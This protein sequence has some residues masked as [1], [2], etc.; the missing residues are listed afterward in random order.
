MVI[1][2]EPPL[3]EGTE[4]A[5]REPILA[6]ASRTEGRAALRFGAAG[7][8]RLGL[9]A[10]RLG[11]RRGRFAGAFFAFRRAIVLF[12]KSFADPRCHSQ[13]RESAISH[14]SVRCV[15]DQGRLFIRSRPRGAYQTQGLLP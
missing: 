11:A 6:G 12:C 13:I 15:A 14:L 3:N 9:G 10:A 4:R 7:A 1:R 5:I 8:L 2:L